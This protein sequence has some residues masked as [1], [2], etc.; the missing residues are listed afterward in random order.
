[1]P[2]ILS[3]ALGLSSLCSFAQAA[4]SPVWCVLSYSIV[5]LQFLLC[6]LRDPSQATS[7]TRQ[8]HINNPRIFTWR[9]WW[10]HI[11][12]PLDLLEKC[13][14]ETAQKYTCIFRF[15]MSFNK[16]ECI[17]STTYKYI[18]HKY[19]RTPFGFNT[20]MWG[21]LKFAPIIPSHLPPFHTASN[22]KLGG[23]WERTQMKPLSSQIYT[24]YSHS[25]LS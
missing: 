10:F 13:G 8:C 20:L 17:Y 16:Y 9:T 24:D 15:F 18:Q 4:V 22:R 23:T 5:I 12:Y 1:M 6:H 2:C 3:F 25:V 21:S 19:I 7:T 14:C 11:N